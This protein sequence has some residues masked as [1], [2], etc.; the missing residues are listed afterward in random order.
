MS[1]KNG[2]YAGVAREVDT[3]VIRRQHEPSPECAVAVERAAGREV[4]RRRE[5][6][7]RTR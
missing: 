2:A 7:R 4:V 3:R 5:R 6:D 1:W